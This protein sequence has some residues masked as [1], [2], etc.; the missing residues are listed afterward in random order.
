MI[1]YAQSAVAGLDGVAEPMGTYLH[2]NGEVRQWTCLAG[3]LTL[4]INAYFAYMIIFYGLRMVELEDPDIIAN[5][6][7]FDSEDT[8]IAYLTD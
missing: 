3:L 4:A 7:G 1:E 2:Y 5:E 6:K 8:P